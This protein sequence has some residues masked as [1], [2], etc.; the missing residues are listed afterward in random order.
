[1]FVLQT[2]SLFET[3]MGRTNVGLGCSSEFPRMLGCHPI[4]MR[5]SNICSTFQT[6]QV[7]VMVY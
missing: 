5:S 7:L 1:M 4:T 6:N 2:M 3:V